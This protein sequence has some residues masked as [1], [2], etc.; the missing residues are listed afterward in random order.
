MTKN[1]NQDAI[2]LFDIDEILWH[3]ERKKPKEI[4]I[5]ILHTANAFND[6]RCKRIFH[7]GNEIY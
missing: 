6:K 3:R 2:T 7:H 4:L 1:M 5:N